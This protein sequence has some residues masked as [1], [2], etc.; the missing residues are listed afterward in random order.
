MAFISRNVPVGQSLYIS[1]YRYIL[2][3]LKQCSPLTLSQVSCLHHL[4]LFHYTHHIHILP[5]YI[6]CTKVYS[7]FGSIQ[8]NLAVGFIKCLMVFT[9]QNVE[10]SL[11]MDCLCIG[12]ILQGTVLIAW[13]FYY[14]VCILIYLQAMVPAYLS[15]RRSRGI[16]PDS[17]VMDSIYLGLRFY[18]GPFHLS[19]ISQFPQTV[20]RMML[21]HHASQRPRQ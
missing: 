4:L 2:E 16:Y 6:W 13:C 3:I 18:L 17:L 15:L 11:L 7:C 9:V 21:L 8:R 12:Y 1:R 19:F 10:F 20:P 14:F 5:T